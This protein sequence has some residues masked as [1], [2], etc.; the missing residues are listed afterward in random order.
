MRKIWVLLEIF[1]IFPM[2]LL[3]D[4]DIIA[5]LKGEYRVIAINKAGESAE[6]NTVNVVL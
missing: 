5:A 3:E 2:Q 4:F 1:Q 6:S